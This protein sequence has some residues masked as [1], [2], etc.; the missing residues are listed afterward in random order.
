MFCVAATSWFT[1]F[2][3]GVWALATSQGWHRPW[4]SSNFEPSAWAACL[5]LPQRCQNSNVNP[6][7]PQINQPRLIYQE[8]PPPNVPFSGAPQSSTVAF[9]GASSTH[10]P[11]AITRST[12]TILSLALLM[13]LA[14]THFPQLLECGRANSLQSY[15]SSQETWTCCKDDPETSKG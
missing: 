5:A 1:R 10:A 8:I 6:C 13:Q 7:Q 12:Q 9:P 15:H 3:K 14:F 11:W 4:T 2:V